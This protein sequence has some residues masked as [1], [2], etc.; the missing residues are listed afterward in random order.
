M[1]KI[2]LTLFIVF[3][4]SSLFANESK[5]CQKCHPLIYKEYYSSIHRKSSLANDKIYKAVFEKE[6]QVADKST[7]KT[8]HSPSAKTPKETKEE[9]ISCVYCH[10]ITDIQKHEDKN[11]N[12]LSDKKRDF[13]SMKQQAHFLVLSNAQK[14]LLT[15]R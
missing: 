2:L 4:L 11:K 3:N 8:C 15:I 14:T 12:I 10:T 13:Y 9:P 7:C 5:V 6:K 1:K